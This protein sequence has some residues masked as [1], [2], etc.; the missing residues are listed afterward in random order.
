VGDALR[1]AKLDAIRREVPP[2]VW[3]A[4]VTVGDPMVRV[5]LREPSAGP[6]RALLLASVV[7]A[8]GL[9]FAMVRSR[10]RGTSWPRT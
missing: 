10:V 4:F 5:A 1:A 3:A 6:R 2:R 8:A 7:A 9:A